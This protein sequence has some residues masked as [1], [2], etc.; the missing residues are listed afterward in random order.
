MRANQQDWKCLCNCQVLPSGL[1]L[2]SPAQKRGELSS[3]LRVLPV[4]DFELSSAAQLTPHYLELVM[5][6]CP[7]RSRSKVVLV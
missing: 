6:S 1:G 5:P 3:H 2:C 4:S 7:V